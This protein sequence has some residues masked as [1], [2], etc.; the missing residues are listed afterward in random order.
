MPVPLQRTSR[1]LS[2]LQ[3]EA[4]SAVAP[5]V[6]GRIA[7]LDGLSEAQIGALAVRL[8]PAQLSGMRVLPDAWPL[9]PAESE[10]DSSPGAAAD[11]VL[12][13]AALS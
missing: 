6:A 2:I 3:K 12:L 13:I 9:P 1:A 4:K 10:Q 5:H 11:R 8:S 7:D